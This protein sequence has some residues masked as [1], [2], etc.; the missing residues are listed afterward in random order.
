V[1]RCIPL[2]EIDNA[3]LLNALRL[4]E[5]LR[6][7]SP[8]PSRNAV[9]PRML[10]PI[11]RNT[12]LLKVVDGGAD[13]EYRIV[14][15]AYVMAHGHSYQGMRWSQTAGLAKGFH[16]VVKPIFDRVVRE[17]EP[18]AMRGWIDRGGASTGHVY[19]EYLYLPLGEPGGSVDFILVCAIYLR[20]G[21]TESAIAGSSSFTI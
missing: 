7:G 15:D 13:Y 18:V 12:M 21:G 11:L 16:K 1:S 14:G 10:K 3:V 8:Y 4:W 6:G 2:E 5:D 20:R 9:T 19:C 17:G